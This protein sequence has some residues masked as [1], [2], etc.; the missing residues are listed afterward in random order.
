[1]KLYKE[2]KDLY[3]TYQGKSIFTKDS[4]YKTHK[5]EIDQF[6]N[7]KRTLEKLVGVNWKLD[8]KKWEKEI[9][10][11][12]DELQEI[13]TQKEEIKEH[14]NHINHI[15]YATKVVTEE[16]GIDL[17]VVIDNAVKNGGKVSIISQLEFYKKQ[18]EKDEV[19]RQKAKE[20]NIEIER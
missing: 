18:V 1:M 11:L 16:Y 2:N 15:K 19:Y 17:S 9:Q 5:K 3:K 6:E 7:V 13:N 10:A 12:K 8:P 4:F 20:K 14:Y